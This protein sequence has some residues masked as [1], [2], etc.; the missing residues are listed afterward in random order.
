MDP[1][2][3][4]AFVTVARER[5]FTQAALALH[6]S[7]SAVSQQVAGLEQE[8]GA[9]L[10]DR[11]GRSVTLTAAGA[12]LLERAE[13]LLTEL[14]SARRAVAFAEGRIAG[15]LRIASSLT[16]AGYVLPKALAAFRHE[17]PEV[18]VELR[19]RNTEDVARALAAG[20]VDLGL[21]EGDVEVERF[22]LEPL[23]EDELAVILPPTHRFARLDEIE[24]DELAHEPIVLREQGSGTRQIAEAALSAHGLDHTSLQIVAEVSGIDALKAIVEAGLGVSIVSMLTIRRELALGTLVARPV[25]G[26][27]MYRQLAAARLAAAPE[28]PAARALVAALLPDR[29]AATRTG[30]PGS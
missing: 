26:V 8:L 3:L 27:P 11:S 9:A 6:L 21:L 25:R 14:E 22:V 16:L 15:D 10:L 17:H 30:R 1:R 5:S 28:L 12:V 4:R 19:V 2:R 20:E 24:P 23:L 18:R 7:Q 13:S 29:Q